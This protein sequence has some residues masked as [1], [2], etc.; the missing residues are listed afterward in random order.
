MNLPD[1]RF[2]DML[3]FMVLDWTDEIYLEGFTRTITEVDPREC[4]NYSGALSGR[5]DVFGYTGLSAGT[6]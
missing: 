2:Q 4:P 1:R 3:S 6:A 5:F